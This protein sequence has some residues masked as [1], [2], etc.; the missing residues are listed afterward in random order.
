MAYSLE[1]IAVIVREA[2]RVGYADCDVEYLGPEH[3]DEF[4]ALPKGGVE[5]GTREYDFRK[6]MEKLDSGVICY[7]QEIM[8]S[9]LRSFRRVAMENAYT[10]MKLDRTIDWLWRAVAVFGVLLFVVLG[11]AFHYAAR[12]GHFDGALL[13][14]TAEVRRLRSE[15]AHERADAQRDAH[16]ALSRQTLTAISLDTCTVNANALSHDV[17]ALEGDLERCMGIRRHRR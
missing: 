13:A 11:A 12:A 3:S 16:A 15:L 1:R 10:A 14:Q 8:L 2:R 7:R 17:E 6:A 5:N 9:S 4:I